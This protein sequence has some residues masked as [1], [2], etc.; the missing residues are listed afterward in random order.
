VNWLAGERH[1]GCHATGQVWETEGFTKERE[2]KVWQGVKYV[3]RL[4]CAMPF[5][6]LPPRRRR[7]V[8]R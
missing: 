7:W 3:K 2:Y 6:F 1:E 5:F 8:P 4:E